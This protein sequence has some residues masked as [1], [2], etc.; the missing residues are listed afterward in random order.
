MVVLEGVWFLKL[1]V[2]VLILTDPFSVTFN[3]NVDGTDFHH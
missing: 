2:G 3:K 1:G